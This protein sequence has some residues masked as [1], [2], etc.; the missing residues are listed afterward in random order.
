MLRN[1]RGLLFVA[2]AV[3]LVPS[4]GVA[5]DPPKK[6]AVVPPAPAMIP[7]RNWDPNPGDQAEIFGGDAP[8]SQNY[9]GF[10]EWAKFTE[11][12]DA[13]G[14]NGL[15]DRR[16]VIALPMGTRVLIVKRYSPPPAPSRTMSPEDFADLAISTSLSAP[17]PKR[18][19]P[20]EVRILDGEFKDQIRFVPEESVARMV[21]APVSPK[22][23]PKYQPKPADP[24]TRAATTLR[25]AQNLERAKKVPAALGLYRQVVRDHPGTPEAKS[26]AERIRALG[27]R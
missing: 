7:D 18:Q 6:A 4:D 5:D 9:I 23:K 24:A 12:G 19:Y 16:V 11:A 14:K 8:S 27:E 15:Y 22:A 3:G 10:R 21:P 2:V 1:S 20:L 26:A 25:S 13:I 17:A